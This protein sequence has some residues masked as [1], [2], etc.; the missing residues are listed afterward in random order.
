MNDSLL[1]K[2]QQTLNREMP[3]TIPMGLKAR[4][5]DGMRLSMSMPL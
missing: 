1:E 4:S 3:I 5:W 2:L